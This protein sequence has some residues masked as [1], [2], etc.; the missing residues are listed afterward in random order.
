M[1]VLKLRP[2]HWPHPVSIIESATHVCILAK[3]ME[4]ALAHVTTT[5]P[6]VDLRQVASCAELASK[7]NYV[8]NANNDTLYAQFA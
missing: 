7:Y 5:T 6:E 2:L 8:F 4:K 1:H 3:S